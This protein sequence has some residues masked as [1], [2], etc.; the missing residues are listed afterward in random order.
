M[1]KKVLH[2]PKVNEEY[3][4]NL[5]KIEVMDLYMQSFGQKISGPDIRSLINGIFGINLD[6]IA[7]LESSGVSLFSKEQWISQYERDLFVVHTGVTDVDVWVYPTAYFTEQTSLTE[8]PGELQEKLKILGF[9]YN[10][11]VKAFYYSHP[12]GESVSDD[13]KGQTLGTI[14]AFVHTYYEEI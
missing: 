8:L 5:S 1:S 6:G 4:M 10:E 7:G 2:S 13:F 14:I 11:G 12:N 9:T 3:L